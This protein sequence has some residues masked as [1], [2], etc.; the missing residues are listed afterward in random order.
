MGRVA[1]AATSGEGCMWCSFAFSLY[2]M[3]PQLNALHPP[4]TKFRRMGR[5]GN[6]VGKFSCGWWLVIYAGPNLPGPFRCLKLCLSFCVLRSLWR[7]SVGSFCNIF[8]DGW[9]LDA[10]PAAPGFPVVH[11]MY[12]FSWI[13]PSL[14]SGCPIEKMIKVCLG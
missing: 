7:P 11:F 9:R 12:R 6:R 1:Q 8:S 14:P 3:P 10:P 2:S 4:G 5:W 13:R